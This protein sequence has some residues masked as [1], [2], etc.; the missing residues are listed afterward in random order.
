M[1]GIIMDL[2]D[3]S[4][5][6]ELMETREA[7]GIRWFIMIVLLIFL[8]GIGFAC[9]SDMDEY[10]RVRGEVKTANAQGDV[11][12]ASSC[13][14]NSVNVSEGQK[15]SAGETLFVLDSDY[16]R[17]QK[18]IIEDQLLSYESDLENTKLLKKSV[19]EN[20]NLFTNKGEE[21]KFYY[22]YE[23]YNNG[24]LLSSNELEKEQTENQ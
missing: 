1:K 10:V 20:K 13:R 2:N 21:S 18:K 16:A 22:R 24:I 12:S 6:R 15:V 5:S 4:D 11:T 23:Q 8:S 7:P 17:K 14:I 3:I 19:E 9:F